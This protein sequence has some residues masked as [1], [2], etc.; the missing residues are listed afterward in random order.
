MTSTT[1]HR[2]SFRQSVSK[3]HT[4]QLVSCVGCGW[5]P[6]EAIVPLRGEV[7]DDLVYGPAIGTC[8]NCHFVVR[9]TA[10]TTEPQYRDCPCGEPLGVQ[11]DRAIARLEASATPEKL[12]AERAAMA[13]L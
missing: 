6:R 3:F 4:D 10:N 9:D 11:I 12:A 5:L 7:E 2:L 1:A 8:P 13:R